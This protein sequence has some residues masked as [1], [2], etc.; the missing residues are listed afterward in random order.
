MREHVGTQ[1]CN[2]WTQP[3][4]FPPWFPAETSTGVGFCDPRQKSPQ[5]QNFHRPLSPTPGSDQ[6]TGSLEERDTCHLHCRL[7]IS[8]ST[9]NYTALLCHLHSNSTPTACTHTHANTVSTQ[10]I[11][12]QKTTK[13]INLTLASVFMRDLHPPSS[14]G[15]RKLHDSTFS[16]GNLGAAKELGIRV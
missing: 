14:G 3:L 9:W 7:P 11:W 12:K 8:P 16:Q 6:S 15:R 2:P 4:C 13:W 10:C 5:K 1:A